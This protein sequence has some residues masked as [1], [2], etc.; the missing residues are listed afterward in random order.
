MASEIV[1]TLQPQLNA[2]ASPI[3]TLFVGA[4]AGRRQ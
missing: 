1:R 2:P 4:L 3:I